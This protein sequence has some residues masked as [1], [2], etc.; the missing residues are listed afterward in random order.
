MIYA[1]NLI[2]QRKKQSYS[3]YITK[4]RRHGG[5]MNAFDIKATESETP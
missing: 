3:D 4:W 1:K 2:S 5:D